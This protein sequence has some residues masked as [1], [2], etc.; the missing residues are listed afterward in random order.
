MESAALQFPVGQGADGGHGRPGSRATDS[1]AGS[2]RL[3]RAAHRAGG[4]CGTWDG[5]TLSARRRRRGNAA[6]SV[7]AKARRGRFRS[8]CLTT[9]W[10]PP[11]DRAP[12]RTARWLP[13]RPASAAGAAAGLAARRGRPRRCPGTGFG[14]GAVRDDGLI[15]ELAD[16]SEGEPTTFYTV[17]ADRPLVLATLCFFRSPR[18]GVLGQHSP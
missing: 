15:A 17:A 14:C 1:L 2:F 12:S 5:P 11:G 6:A 10:F 7:E 8:R 13:P 4:R 3:G 16:A 9:T 18:R